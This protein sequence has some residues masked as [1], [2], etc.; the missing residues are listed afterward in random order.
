MG[1]L[2]TKDIN[3]INVVGMQVEHLLARCYVK[4][5]RLDDENIHIRGVRQFL[6]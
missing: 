5:V 2:N 6:G 3:V 1:L 4:R